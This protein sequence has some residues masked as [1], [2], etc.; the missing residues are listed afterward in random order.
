M[1]L[2]TDSAT[3]YLACLT[4]LCGASVHQ[5]HFQDHPAG[6]HPDVLRHIH[7]GADDDLRSALR[8]VVSTFISIIDFVTM[9]YSK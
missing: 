8:A 6:G 2:P 4:Y 3:T 5:D 9:N 1:Y 7:R